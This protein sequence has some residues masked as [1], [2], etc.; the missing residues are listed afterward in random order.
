M[1]SFFEFASEHR[2]LDLLI[3]ER[4][5]V[6]LNG[7]LENI[8]PATIARK[9]EN[10]VSLSVK[11]QISLLMPP[12]DS[13]CRPS[14]RERDS[15][16]QDE[17]KRT[18]TIK[19]QLLARS[20]AITIAK[21]RK[22]GDEYKY[23]RYLDEFIASIRRDIVSDNPLK[24]SSIKI[25]G[26]KKSVNSDNVIILRP[27][28]LF[29]S[30]R[31]KLLIALASRYLSEVFDPFLH[32]EIISYRPPRVYHE[33]ESK[34]ITTRDHAIENIQ[35]YRRSH[36]NIYVAECDI[37]KYFDTINHDVIRR[38]FREFAERVR[39]VHPDFD[40]SAVS[41]IVDA[42]L[43]SYSFYNNVLHEND[44]LLK[45]NPP[46]VYE[47]PKDELFIKRGCYTE[48]E[49]IKSKAKIGIPQGGALS[50]LISNVVLNTIDRESVLNRP[51]PNLFFCRYGDDIMLMHTSRKRC[52]ELI[53]NYCRALSE[54]K[55]LYHDFV[56]V[57]DDSIRR[58]DGTI[59]T[60]F[61][62]LKS[63]SPFLWGRSDDEVEKV[64]WIGFLGYE[65]RYTGE[66]R[67][68]RS[69]L[70][71]KFRGIKRKYKSC[72]DSV[73]AK[74]KKRLK[75]NETVESE[76]L[77]HIDKFVGEG[78]ANAKSLNCNKYSLTQARKL[79]RY[80]GHWM[81][82][83]IYKMVRR[84]GL[85]KCDAVR[86]WTEVKKRGCLNYTKTIK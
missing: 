64:D 67:I 9:A 36:K 70:N 85:A 39:G 75:R 12:R 55:L 48:E 44:H 84:N 42:Y 65:I 50:G 26:K 80:T 40:Y 68:R 58:P 53:A 34:V 8:S 25:I 18:N 63:R 56:S 38:C 60:A 62:D 41:R 14:K 23:L 1:L 33:S 32:S 4:V 15:M 74:G 82:K 3:K 13:W 86:L 59:R 78:F 79:D 83:M 22:S 72:V 57:A 16:R 29:E 45:A 7:R 28:C 11:E 66:V 37:Q 27:L 2:I 35:A 43:D 69:S 17:G 77:R 51:D 76:I 19:K 30:L 81:F 49:F 20:I 10:A 31:E 54:S 61:W 6:A 5:K 24:F 46:R 52:E 47:G 71:D 73:F 21:H